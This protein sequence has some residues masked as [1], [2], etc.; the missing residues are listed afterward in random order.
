LPNDLSTVRPEDVLPPA[1]LKISV[2][3]L[4]GGKSDQMLAECLDSVFTALRQ[5][6][7]GHEVFVIDNG[8]KPPLVERYPARYPDLRVIRFPERVG[9]CASNNWA[10][11]LSRG[12]FLLQLNDD[13]VIEPDALRILVDYLDQHP[14]V[15]CVGPKLLKPDGTV[16]R[17]GRTDPNLLFTLLDLFWMLRLC[18]W[19]PAIRRHLLLD[20]NPDIGGKFDGH[21]SGA[22]LLYRRTMLNQ[23]GLLDENFTFAFDDPDICLRIRQAGWELHYVPAARVMHEDG[24]TLKEHPLIGLKAAWFN[25]SL[26]F[27]AKQ[28]P[29]R[30][31]AFRLIFLIALL[32]RIPIVTVVALVRPRNLAAARTHWQFF[33]IVLRSFFQRL[34]DLAR[35]PRPAEVPWPANALQNVR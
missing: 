15:G 10:F 21:L 30:Y 17:Y 18:P 12:E 4:T 26:R 35:T 32:F 25:G 7:G 22:S 1:S 14:A 8:C 16:G 23:V 11:R 24:F 27:W 33:G 2:V 5:V 29:E 28:S 13:T 3:I 20:R 31:L 9:F 6:P 19:I 34:P